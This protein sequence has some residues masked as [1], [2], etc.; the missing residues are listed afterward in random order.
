[1][2]KGCLNLHFV[3]SQ[4]EWILPGKDECDSSKMVNLYMYTVKCVNIGSS[5]DPFLTQASE[6]ALLLGNEL[7]AE[8]CCR[9]S[10]CSLLV[11]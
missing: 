3:C 5:K 2:D 8:V 6:F 7:D 9:P 10:C 1:M 11:T 4:G